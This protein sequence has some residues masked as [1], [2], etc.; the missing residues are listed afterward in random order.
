MAK[1][2]FCPF[3][4]AELRTNRSNDRPTA[5]DLR[6]SSLPSVVFSALVM[7]AN[8]KH[9]TRAQMAE[10]TPSIHRMLMSIPIDWEL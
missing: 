7:Q 6:G 9:G 4:L 3:Y 2:D 1:V 10:K 5:R 8:D